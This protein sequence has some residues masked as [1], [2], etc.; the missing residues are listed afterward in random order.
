[1]LKKLMMAAATVACASA[2][3]AERTFEVVYQGFHAE[4]AGVFQADKTVE[5]LIK[6]DDLNGDGDYSHDELVSLQSGKIGYYGYCG[7]IDCV[8]G[9]SWEAG[10]EPDYYAAY[11]YLNSF[12]YTLSDI[13][14]G[15]EINEFYQSTNGFRYDYTWTWTD[16]TTTTITEISP[17]PEPAQ[18]GMLAAGLAG[19]VVLA[20]RRRG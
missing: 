1:M 16:A 19:M 17:V 8:T 5:V 9:F 4:H 18:Y 3:A 12:D 10:K 7:I 2:G 14:T 13:Y 11:T 20:R 6:V 15:H